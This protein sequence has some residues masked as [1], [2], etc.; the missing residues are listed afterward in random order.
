MIASQVSFSTSRAHVLRGL[1]T[2][3]YP[4]FVSVRR[5]PGDSDGQRLDVARALVE[6]GCVLVKSSQDG[7]AD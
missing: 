2:S 1:H 4:K 3:P 5:L 7:V 6:A